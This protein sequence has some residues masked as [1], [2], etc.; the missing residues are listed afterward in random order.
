MPP[1]PPERRTSLFC[2]CWSGSGSNL[3]SSLTTALE[4]SEHSSPATDGDFMLFGR[5]TLRIS[6]VHMELPGSDKN[7]AASACLVVVAHV[8]VRSDRSQLT[9]LQHQVKICTQYFATNLTAGRVAPQVLGHFTLY[10]YNEPLAVPQELH[11]A[12]AVV[13]ADPPY[14]VRGFVIP[15]KMS[16][17]WQKSAGEDSLTG[18]R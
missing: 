13:V 6:P 9:Q 12:F 10:D 1:T 16:V 5:L 14:L 8:R 3:L 7:S 2:R 11:G 17:S 15:Q 4:E 18:I